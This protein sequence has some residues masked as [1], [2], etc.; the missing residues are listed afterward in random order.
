MKLAS[1]SLIDVKATIARREDNERVPANQ[2]LK[3]NFLGYMRA[4][5]ALMLGAVVWTSGVLEMGRAF[6]QRA[7]QSE[8]VAGNLS[9]NS[10][11]LFSTIDPRRVAAFDC[12]SSDYAGKY[13]CAADKKIGSGKRQ[14]YKRTTITFNK[15]NGELYYIFS[16]E[17]SRKRGLKNLFT[18]EINRISKMVGPPKEHMVKTLP[19]D[20]HPSHIVYWG[21]IQLY[22]IDEGTRLKVL[23]EVPTGKG[24]LVDYDLAIRYSAKKKYPIYYMRGE[25]GYILNYLMDNDGTERIAARL[26]A[27]N[28]IVGVLTPA[29]R[30]TPS[31]PVVVMQVPA[32]TLPP[33]A[34]VATPEPEPAPSSR[35]APP[36]VRSPAPPVC[37]PLRSQRLT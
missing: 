24:Y 32:L 5:F 7:G 1:A 16:L 36:V 34:P 35:A 13:V 15:N 21:N 4:L 22:Q 3:L 11:R 2:T 23:S 27:P 20:R 14:I 25:S 6:G 17:K 10:L 28:A 37:E 30:P 8:L 31:P 29:P 9:I 19:G 26:V 12:E 33:P 18:R